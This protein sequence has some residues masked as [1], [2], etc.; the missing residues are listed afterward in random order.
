MSDVGKKYLQH[1]LSTVIDLDTSLEHYGVKGMKWNESKAS[2]E[3]DEETL[4]NRVARRNKELRDN[5]DSDASFNPDVKI[6]TSKVVF[7]KDG[8]TKPK[9]AIPG[10]LSGTAKIRSKSEVTEYLKKKKSE[11][12]KHDLF[13]DL[14][15]DF[16]EHYGVLGM[17]WGVRKD[18]VSVRRARREDAKTLKTSRK[19][20]KKTRND[21]INRQVKEMTDE[22]L[23]SAIDRLANEKRFRELS[24]ADQKR[25][26][27]MLKSIAKT[28]LKNAATS[29]GTKYLERAINVNLNKVVP[30]EYRVSL[31]SKKK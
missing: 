28:S 17:R 5:P 15:S 7:L 11:S 18:R 12:I 25:G 26:E 29:V 21:R 31:N 22:E 30:V 27:S 1:R 3:E 6:D 16:L 24:G 2:N 4:K 10:P 8:D 14:G 13:T 20:A 19:E 23:R 9:K